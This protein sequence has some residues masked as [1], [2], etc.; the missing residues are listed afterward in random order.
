MNQTGKQGAQRS[1]Q[2]VSRAAVPAAMLGC[3]IV[4]S[5]CSTLGNSSENRDFRNRVYVGA[6][7]L[8]SQLEPDTSGVTGVSVDDSMGAG[9]SLTLGYDIDNRFSVEGHIASLG[10]ATLEPTGTIDYTVAG[11]SGLVYGLN[12]PNDRARREGFSVFGRLGLGALENDAS[13]VEFERVNDVHL[14]AGLG[15]E[16][17]LNNGLGLRAELVAHETD[18]KYVQLGLV[19]RIGSHRYGS[20]RS[21]G[22]PVAPSAVDDVPIVGPI[23]DQL[24]PVPVIEPEPVE[25]LPPVKPEKIT[26]PDADGDKV[27][28]A[29]DKCLDTAPGAPVRVD[30]CPIFDGVVEG[31]NFRAGSARLTSE[32]NVVLAGVAQTLRDYPDIRV[33]IEAH[34][35]NEGAASANLQLSK[36]R[37]IAV[38]RYL[39]D[40]GISGSRLK[41]QAF[42]ESKPRTSNL[43]EQGR[44]ANRRV[45]FSVLQ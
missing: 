32:A 12:Q 27:P 31:V 19:Y 10:E 1:A 3:I 36:R 40:A 38:A 39:V 24:P 11:V 43:T 16:Y 23:V 33:I 20:P 13:G 17:G 35:D 41:P 29:E 45:E 9:G 14:L 7:V 34:T 26:P 28:D 18:A 25:E 15:L 22:Q 5:G 42:G 21:T 8:A 37:A 30:G 4:L 44:A 2:G 6:G